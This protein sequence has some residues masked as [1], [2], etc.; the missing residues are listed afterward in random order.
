MYW[1]HY[2]LVQVEKRCLEVWGT[3]EA[4]EEAI[5]LKEDKREKLKDKKI[6]KKMLGE[7]L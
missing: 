7:V 2:S 1:I 6:K 4:L 5:A 3:E